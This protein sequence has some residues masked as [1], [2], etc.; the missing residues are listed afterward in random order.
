MFTALEG[1]GRRW[2]YNITPAR[3]GLTLPHTELWLQPQPA[4]EV[5][6]RGRYVQVMR[7][8][9]RGSSQLSPL[10]EDVWN[11]EDCNSPG[12]EGLCSVVSPVAALCPCHSLWQ[13]RVLVCYS[14]A[15]APD[16]R[17]LDS[18]STAQHRKLPA[19]H[20]VCC[21]S[22]HTGTRWALPTRVYQPGDQPAP[23][24]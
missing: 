9:W 6:Y 14:V 21:V 22:P 16:C 5:K 1:G 10:T 20:G 7:G 11:I 18:P 2:S 13:S 12:W 4:L 17:A 8:E 3:Q 19:T 24:C 23:Q 15:A